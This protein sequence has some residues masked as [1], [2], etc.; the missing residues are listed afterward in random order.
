MK[1][2]LR[3]QKQSSIQKRMIVKDGVTQSSK[4]KGDTPYYKI[5]LVWLKFTL[6]NLIIQKSPG[7]SF[8]TL[9]HACCINQT[10]DGSLRRIT[11]LS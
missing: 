7:K 8:E 10:G 5:I 4:L 11:L 6:I 2:Q 1:E 3:K 9:H